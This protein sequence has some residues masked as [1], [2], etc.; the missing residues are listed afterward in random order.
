MKRYFP[1]PFIGFIYFAFVFCIATQCK[2]D[3]FDKK[4]IELIVFEKENIKYNLMASAGNA[5]A[6]NTLILNRIS[7]NKEYPVKT[8][9][10]F[11]I[12]ESYSEFYQINDSVFQISLKTL[13]GNI[14]TFIIYFNY[15][16]E[17]RLQKK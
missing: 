10:T 2:F 11:Y 6:Q 5:T 12:Y 14:D 4:N 3:L 1:M 7:K 17:L 15:N 13:K 16:N 9:E 8:L